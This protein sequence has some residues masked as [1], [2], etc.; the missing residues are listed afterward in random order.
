LDRFG[1]YTYGNPVTIR[2]K[3][4]DE[5][6]RFTD[7]DGN[8][9]VSK[10]VVFVDREVVAG[11]FLAKGAVSGADPRSIGAAKTIQSVSGVN[12]MGN[13]IDREIHALL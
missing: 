3:W 5:A 8:E 11:G 4:E 2:C 9:R 7:Q 12:A 10:S 1:N 6:E 13:Q